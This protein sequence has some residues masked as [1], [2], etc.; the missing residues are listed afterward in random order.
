M[1]EERSGYL[2]RLLMLESGQADVPF[3]VSLHAQQE[4]KSDNQPCFSVGRIESPMPHCYHVPGTPS[5]DCFEWPV[6]RTPDH[7]QPDFQFAVTAKSQLS[8]FISMAARRVKKVW[9]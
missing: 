8:H 4:Q 2:E 6:E 1:L 5:S 3:R 9:A 7:A